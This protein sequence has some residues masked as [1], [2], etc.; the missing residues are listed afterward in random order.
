MVHSSAESSALVL[1]PAALHLHKI[2]SHGS[3]RLGY[4]GLEGYY[5]P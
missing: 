3:S 1:D 5:L 4:S 2:G